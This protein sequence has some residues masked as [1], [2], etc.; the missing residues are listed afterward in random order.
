MS[1]VN[2]EVLVVVCHYNTRSPQELIVL[3]DQMATT[4]AGFPFQVRVVVNLASPKRLALPPRHR[5]VEVVY[6]DNSGYNIGAWEYGWCLGSPHVGYLFLQEECRLARE[7]WVAAFVH[8]A[9]E[10]GIGLVGECLSPIW[11]APWDELAQRL[12]GE[13][14]PD[15]WIE[16]SPA[17]RVP[18]YL[19]FLNRQGIPPGPRGDHLQSLILFARR[20]ILEAIQGFPVGGNYGEAIAAEI[21]ISKKV[22]ALGLRVVEVGPTPFW[23]IEHPQWLHRRSSP[24]HP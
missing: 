17:E 6:R 22:Q 10:V 9:S 7:G 1:P 14:L 20:D 3:L 11:D 2:D 5:N 16:D 23:Y 18:C 24:A 8:R 13:L 15:H 4:P 21:G 12:Q 19:D